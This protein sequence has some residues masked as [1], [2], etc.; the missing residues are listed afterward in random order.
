MHDWTGTRIRAEA[1]T[2]PCR[3]CQAQPGNDCWTKDQDPRPL[4][5]FRAHEI[6]IRDA[7]KASTQA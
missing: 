5:A 6:R 2:V 3:Y 7:Q 1:L 4:T